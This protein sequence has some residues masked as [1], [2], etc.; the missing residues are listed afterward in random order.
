MRG[1]LVVIGEERAISEV[2]EICFTGGRGIEDDRLMLLVATWVVLD[3]VGWI[4]P[5]VLGTLFVNEEMAHPAHEVPLDAAAL[6]APDAVESRVDCDGN[7]VSGIVAANCW[8]RW[9]YI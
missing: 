8:I 4:S 9:K 5:F 3:G 2:C 1:A 7:A 6:T